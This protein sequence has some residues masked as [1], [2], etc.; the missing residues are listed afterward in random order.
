MAT[1]H[2]VINAFLASPGDVAEERAL[3][4]EI[5]TEL[6]LTWSKTLQI[7]LELIRWETHTT[8]GISSY[9]QQVINQQIGDEYDIFIGLLW[10]HFGSATPKYSSGTAEEFERALAR[11]TKDPESVDIMFYF[12]DAPISPSQM[13]V[14]QIT[15]VLN[16]KSSLGDEGLLYWSFTSRD[17]FVQ[18]LRLHLS[19]VIQRWKQKTNSAQP[20]VIST[21]T[22]PAATDL[23][24]H[25]SE[26]PDDLGFFDHIEEGST[27]FERSTECLNKIAAAADAIGAAMNLRTEEMN[28]SKSQTGQRSIQ[29]VQKIAKST[30]QDLNDFSARME[31][32]TPL[33]SDSYKQAL[34]HV[35]AAA[36]LSVEDFT[37]RL[38]QLISLR[39]TTSSNHC[40][41]TDSTGHVLAF[42]QLIAGLP[43]LQS[44]FN[45]AKRRTTKVLDDLIDTL[46]FAKRLTS[47]CLQFLNELIARV[48]RQHIIAS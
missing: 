35:V 10:A 41:I 9:P 45:K 2:L 8:P 15:K 44:A 16:F 11:H 30:A 38:E 34:A 27:A 42:R 4:E 36:N 3:L 33:F 6:N 37:P 14:N 32:E 40:A 19:R 1:H 31:V 26:D 39:D 25:E 22:A 18:L 7:R 47:D 23:D 29:A 20:T 28:H 17:Q 13:D 12:K 43:R 24:D 21:Q 46:E 5:V 48:E